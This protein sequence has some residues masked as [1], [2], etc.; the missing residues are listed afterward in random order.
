MPHLPIQKDVKS[1]VLD[2][3]DT[4]VVERVKY[5]AIARIV[6]VCRIYCDM[7]SDKMPIGLP[8][9]KCKCYLNI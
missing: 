4:A 2:N 5:P 1:Q 8:R 3:A 6:I 9:A 7:A